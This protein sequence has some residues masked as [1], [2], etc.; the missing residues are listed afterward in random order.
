MLMKVTIRMWFMT[1]LIVIT[2]LAGCVSES[3]QRFLEGKLRQDIDRNRSMGRPDY[4]NVELAPL[5]EIL[6]GSLQ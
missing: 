5:G 2:T 1:G 4:E 3:E 6:R